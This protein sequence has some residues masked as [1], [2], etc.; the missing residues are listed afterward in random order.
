MSTSPRTPPRVRRSGREGGYALPAVLAVLVALGLL[1]V[2]ALH[3]ARLDS[4]AAASLAAS[5]RAF[6]AAEAGIALL[7]AG[8]P[9]GVDT[10]AIPGVRIEATRERLLAL[11]DGALLVRLAS[12]ATVTGQGGRTEARRRVSRLRFAPPGALEVRVA[13]SWR[14]AVRP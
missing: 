1:G 3:S 5:V 11:S 9:A 4:L 2:A 12:E 6:Y 8:H 13:G 14:E 10:V 7:E